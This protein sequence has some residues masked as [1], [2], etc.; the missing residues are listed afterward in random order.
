MVIQNIV[1]DEVDK[2]RLRTQIGQGGTPLA[3]AVLDSLNIWKA[4]GGHL[5]GLIDVLRLYSLNALAGEHSD[6]NFDM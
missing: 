2:I 4:G 5:S 3:T 6:G 1:K